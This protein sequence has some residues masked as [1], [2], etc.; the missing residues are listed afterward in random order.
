M[1]ERQKEVLEHLFDLASSYFI[2]TDEIHN[3][4]PVYV[5]PENQPE[6]DFISE[7]LVLC[8]ELLEEDESNG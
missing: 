5:M 6:G 8:G 1:T 7:V 3:G 4:N 2:E